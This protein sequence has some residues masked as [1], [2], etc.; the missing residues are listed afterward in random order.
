VGGRQTAAR[1]VGLGTKNERFK[2]DGAQRSKGRQKRVIGRGRVVETRR[3]L[4]L[5]GLEKRRLGRR[6]GVLVNFSRRVLS[7]KGKKAGDGGTMEMKG[8][9][10][11]RGN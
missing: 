2:V 9:D 3:G 7:G 10:E 11:E 5:S 1:K 4:D 8:S 6:P